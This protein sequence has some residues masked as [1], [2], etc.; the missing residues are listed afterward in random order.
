MITEIYVDN[1]IY[2]FKN[3]AYSNLLDVVTIHLKKKF[4]ALNVYLGKETKKP[5]VNNLSLYSDKLQRTRQ[6]SQKQV[7]KRNFKR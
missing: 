1:Y 3:T 7:D 4:I 5:Q 6:I 2:K